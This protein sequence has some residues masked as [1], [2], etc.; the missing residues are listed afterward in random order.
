MRSWAKAVEKTR[1][2]P[3]T[4]MTTPGLARQETSDGSLGRSG[5]GVVA[6]MDGRPMTITDLGLWKDGAMLRRR[7]S[8]CC[9]GNATAGRD[10]YSAGGGGPG[11]GMGRTAGPA[12]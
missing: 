9:W 4:G 11:G 6:W 10:L 8:S 2:A 5:G 7:L 1:G 12:E 3:S